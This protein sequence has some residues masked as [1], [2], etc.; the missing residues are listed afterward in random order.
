MDKSILDTI[1]ESVND[2][3]KAGLMSELTMCEFDALCNSCAHKNQ[4]KVIDSKH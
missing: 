2:L 3:Y 4:R 1:R